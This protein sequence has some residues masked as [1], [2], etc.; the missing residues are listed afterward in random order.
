M[1]KN[2]RRKTFIC[3]ATNYVL[4]VLTWFAKWT[5][6]DRKCWVKFS[7]YQFVKSYACLLKCNG[8]NRQKSVDRIAAPWLES[9]ILTPAV[10]LF[11]CNVKMFFCFKIL[12]LLQFLTVL[13]ILFFFPLVMLCNY[14]ILVVG[15]TYRK[16]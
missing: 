8:D 4:N 1:S 3:K 9:V 11:C 15:F 16:T 6:T 13:V 5:V 14:G 10:F 2:C 12:I 7:K